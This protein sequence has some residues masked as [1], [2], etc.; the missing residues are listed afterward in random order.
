MTTPK[1]KPDR[2]VRRASED[3]RIIKRQYGQ[4]ETSSPSTVFMNNRTQAVRLPKKVAFPEQVREVEVLKIGFTRVIIP[5]GK[6]WHDLFESGPRVSEDFMTDRDQ[7]IS[8]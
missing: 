2:L 6:R 1:N 8:E 7:G 5:K 3:G 4:M